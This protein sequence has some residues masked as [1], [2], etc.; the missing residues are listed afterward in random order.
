[1]KTSTQLKALIRNISK[2]KNVQAEIVLRNFML[3]RFLERIS[4]SPF[5]NNFIL[6]GGM[7]I[8]ALVGIDARSTMDMDATVVG[9]KLSEEKLEDALQEIL[10]CQVDDN[11]TLMLKGIENIRDESEYPGLRVSIEAT[12]DKTRQVMKIDFT[13][14]DK[15]TPSSMDYYYKL[16]F[17]DRSIHI[18]AYN[19]E[20]VLAEKLETVISRSTA[21]TRMRDYYDIYI[22]TTIREQEINWHLFSKA[23]EN[24][25]KS[26]G[27]FKLIHDEEHESIKAIEESLELANLWHR[28]QQK[29]NYASDISW[30]Q[31]IDR[32]K[33]LASRA[34]ISKPHS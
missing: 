22:L 27:N 5:K 17:E 23:F 4:I 26:R 3:E 7:L 13:T 29:N 16:L 28:Y 12:F 14:G 20:T 33:M 21:T 9:I 19:L 25:V 6:K 8:A 31:A 18:L 15:I 10:S 32:T 2:D 24:T 30:I 11:V 34:F 1:M